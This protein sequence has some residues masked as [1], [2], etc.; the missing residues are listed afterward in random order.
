MVINSPTFLF[1]L[2]SLLKYKVFAFCNLR[3]VLFSIFQHTRLFRMKINGRSTTSL[4][5]RSFKM[6]EEQV[7]TRNSSTRILTTFS[8][9]LT[10]LERIS[11]LDQRDTLKTSI[12]GAIRIHLAGTDATLMTLH[13]A[14]VYLMTCSK[15]WKKCLHLAALGTLH[16]TI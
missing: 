10:F 13:L 14:V 4:G 3:R 16:A 5:M 12:L 6:V 9:N 8:K 7:A 2:Y 1:P 15:I 11:T